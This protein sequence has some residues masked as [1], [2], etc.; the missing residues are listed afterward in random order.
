MSHIRMKERKPRCPV[1]L[2]PPR[3]RGTWEPGHPHG[4][5]CAGS[6]SGTPRQ[7]PIILTSP[8]DISCVSSRTVTLRWQPRPHETAYACPRLARHQ[9]IRTDA[10]LDARARAR[11]LRQTDDPELQRRPRPSLNRTA[12]QSRP[13]VSGLAGRITYDRRNHVSRRPRARL[14]SAAAAVASLFTAVPATAS[15]AV[16][17]ASKGDGTP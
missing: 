9:L 17:Y 10:D 8:S 4:H 11:D 2:A 5:R 15:A 12:R 14:L 6:D 3:G 1:A 16:P 7:N 13:T